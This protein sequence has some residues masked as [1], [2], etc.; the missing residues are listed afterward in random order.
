[1]DE[2]DFDPPAHHEVAVFL[3]AAIVVAL[4]MAYAC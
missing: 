1:M 2:F 3:L 4:M